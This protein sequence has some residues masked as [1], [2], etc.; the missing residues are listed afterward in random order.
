MCSKSTVLVF[1]ALV[2]AL[3]GSTS[4]ANIYWT[5]STGDRDWQ[6]FDNWNVA[7]VTGPV[8]GIT[9]HALISTL[10]GISIG[11]IV[12]ENN[13]KVAYLSLGWH[14]GSIDLIITS[15]GYVGAEGQ[16]LIAKDGTGV[17]NV[18]ISTGGSAY[19][20]NTAIGSTTG[21]VGYLHLDGGEFSA[22]TLI[23]YST[24]STIDISGGALIIAGD[25]TSSVDAWI[26]SGQITGYNGSGRVYYDYNETNT[27]KTTVTAVSSLTKAW[28][29]VPGNNKSGAAT[30]A[31][32]GQSCY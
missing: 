30:D 3:A 24:G 4:A 16:F 23:F 5:N 15:G 27:H 17:C 18:Y 12:D 22:N 19:G 26:A 29:P 7:G 14:G 8:P 6:N 21:A 13:E 31:I 11:P 28:A 20:N 32:L 1:F 10:G 25:A 9:D 2:T